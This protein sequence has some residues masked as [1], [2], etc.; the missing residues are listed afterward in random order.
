MTT[1][2]TVWVLGDQLD[3]ELGA[4]ADA[5]PG[6]DTVVLIT[7]TSKVDG[8][9]WHRQRLHLVLSAMAHLAAELRDAG[10]TV[11]ERTAEDMATG[12][13]Q[14]CAE[15]GI[16]EVVG[17]EANSPVARRMQS[18]LGVR[19]VRSTQFLCHPDDFADWA[20]DRSGRLRMEDFYRWQRVRL[21]VLVDGDEPE[22]GTWN[23]DADNR[24]PPPRD[25]RSWPTN[26]SIALDAIDRRVLDAL[27]DGV[28]GALPAG[29]WPVTRTQAL[30][31]LASFIEHGLP[32]FGPHEDAMLGAEW[33]LAHSTLSSSL[34]LGLLRPREVVAAAEDAYRSGRVPLASAE[35]FIRQIIGWR[36]YVWGL[37]WWWA[38]GPDGGW[39]DW[40]ALD[41][42]RPLPPVFRTGETDMACVANVVEGVRDHAYAHHIERLMVLGN[43]CLL[44][45]VEPVELV[46]W[47]WENFV[48]GAEWV[49]LPNVIGMSL[50]ADGGRMAT[51]PY[52]SGGAYLNRMSDHCRGCRYDPKQRT[53]DDACPFTT[54]YW[55]F[56]ARNEDRLRGNHR[57][58]TQLGGMR[59]LADLDQTRARARDVLGML[60]GGDL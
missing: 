30:A 58:S 27:P 41:A 60:D 28:V 56:L 59:R 34:N 19:T 13:A 33:K 44:A 14:H 43:L 29:D 36:E 1:R 35:G 15:F 5:R 22:G 46:D 45:G 16:D 11:D 32:V 9:P 26:P 12:L 17:T 21:G 53:G 38:D 57:I 2:R 42:H 24:E 25:G 3:A 48:D 37:S 52:A 40:N 10:F 47:M 54:L 23:L 4:L 8:R 20:A 50:W 51:K 49:M 31:R 7:S 39:R 18:R 55:D 6:R